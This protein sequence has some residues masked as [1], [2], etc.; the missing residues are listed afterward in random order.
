MDLSDPVDAAALRMFEETTA[1]ITALQAG[2]KS[3]G[4][5]MIKATMDY[6]LAVDAS[7]DQEAG[8]KMSGDELSLLRQS[9]D[10]IARLLVQ[11]SIEDEEA[12]RL[13]VTVSNLIDRE[14]R[15]EG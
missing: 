1:Y 5:A 7:I 15:S 10:V 2:D 8:G 3:D 6:A 13:V 14:A 12:L 11:H 9:R 4:Q